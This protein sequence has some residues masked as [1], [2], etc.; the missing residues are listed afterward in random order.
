MCAYSFR[1]IHGLDFARKL[2]GVAPWDTTCLVASVDLLRNEWL[3]RRDEY[4]LALGKPFI[5]YQMKISRYAS[6]GLIGPY[7]SA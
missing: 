6:R 1:A 5:I 2:N 7:S 3:R 4:D